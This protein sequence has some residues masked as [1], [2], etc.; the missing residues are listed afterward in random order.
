MKNPDYRH[1]LALY[2]APGITNAMACRLLQRYGSAGAVCASGSAELRAAGVSAAAVR[3]LRAPDG[4]RFE[5]D[6]RW[7]Q[8]DGCSLLGWREPAYPRQLA[9]IEQP[10]PLLFVTGNAALLNEPQI[11]VVGSRR[12]TP[13]GLRNTRYFAE[14][15]ARSGLI[16]VSGLA[17]GID[18]VAHKAALDA[19]APTVAVIGTGSDIVYP[20]ENRFL[21]RRIV[22]HGVVVSEF[23]CGMPPHA[24]NFPRR[25]RLMSGLSLGVLVVEAAHRSGTLITARFAAEQGREVFA[26]PGSIRNPV[27]SGCHR[28]IQQGAKLVQSIE[29]ILVELASVVNWRL[30]DIEESGSPPVEQ[31]PVRSRDGA[32]T[33]G[34]RRL[35]GCMEY[36]EPLGADVLVERSGLT[37]SK[38][39]SMLSLMEVEGYISS[40]G[41]LYTR[42]K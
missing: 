7:S 12:P 28:L 20:T 26:V 35:L 1:R 17:A 30:P 22:E 11:A 40:E 16:V 8:G 3:F 18:A 15:I 13:A 31:Q 32:L 24:R 10:P 5:R 2:H 9:E 34:H 37:I 23:S 33:A 21:A 14:A 41:H 6:V 38:T 4:E 36:D 27:I 39:M 19:P 42:I 29:D 25:N